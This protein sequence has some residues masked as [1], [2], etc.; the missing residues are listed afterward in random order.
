M[1]RLF[2]IALIAIANGNPL[3]LCIWFSQQN[4]SHPVIEVR[5]SGRLCMMCVSLCLDLYALSMFVF[6]CANVFFLSLTAWTI[7]IPPFELFSSWAHLKMWWPHNCPRLPGWNPQASGHRDIGPRHSRQG[8]EWYGLLDGACGAVTW[9]TAEAQDGRAERVHAQVRGDVPVFTSRA[10]G[11]GFL[12]AAVSPVRAGEDE[13][14]EDDG[15]GHIQ[16]EQ[17]ET[18]RQV[19]DHAAAGATQ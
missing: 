14:G 1:S 2:S 19:R 10:R 17:A 8:A 12:C 3:C 9:E 13:Q 4:L 7:S 15:R 16:T 11:F 5:E 18:H 6:M